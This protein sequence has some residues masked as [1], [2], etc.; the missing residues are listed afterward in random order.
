LPVLAPPAAAEQEALALCTA[1]APE[2]VGLALGLLVVAAGTTAATPLEPAPPPPPA[3]TA[4][5]AAPADEDE[6]VVVDSRC[7]PKG[8]TVPITANAATTPK[9]MR[10]SNRSSALPDSSSGT[11]VGSGVVV[12]DQ[13]SDAAGEGAS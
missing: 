6:P 5:M 4:A 8:P 12:M 7:Q 9:A 1:V 10:R 2:V 13:R 11:G 3:P